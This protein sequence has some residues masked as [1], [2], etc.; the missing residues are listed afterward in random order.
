MKTKKLTVPVL[1]IPL[2]CLFFGAACKRFS[3]QPVFITISGKETEPVKIVK[4]MQMKNNTV[5]M[6]FSNTAQILSA[7][8]FMPQTR[9]TEACT[10]KRIRKDC[11]ES[12]CHGNTSTSYTVFALTPQKEMRIGT[13]F[14]VCG[15]V[16]DEKHSVLDF[17]LPFTGSNTQPAKLRITEIRPLYGS[18][19]KSEFIEFVVLQSGNLAGITITNVGDK[20]NPHY[21]FP[22]A[23][24]SRG[25]VVVYH[26]RSV[27]KNI[28]DEQSVRTISGGTQACPAARD[29]WGPYKSLPKRNANVILIKTELHG[30]I[31]DAILYCTTKELSKRGATPTWND[32][33]LAQDAKA[34]VSSGAWQGD[35]SLKSALVA[36]ITAS[37]SL[38]RNAHAQSNN[39]KAWSIRKSKEVTM[40]TA[41]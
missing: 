2:L 5:H 26:W 16:S 31:Q 14:I 1:F 13:P 20:K 36:P 9:Q 40:G 33:S 25:E 12:E 8:I 17:A 32:A 7:H 30:D 37:K 35:A 19:P 23:E 38:V 27:E 34:A 39:A 18:K 3:K 24:V 28:R 29:F 11:R 21:Q 6:Y 22:P 4:T 15:S 10:F 41:Y